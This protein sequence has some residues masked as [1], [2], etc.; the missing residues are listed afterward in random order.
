MKWKELLFLVR[1]FREFNLHRCRLAAKGGMTWIFPA[2]RPRLSLGKWVSIFLF[3]CS[4]GFSAEP[5]QYRS[6]TRLQPRPLKIHI[7]TFDLRNPEI[8]FIILMGKDPDGE[9]PAE[10]SLSDPKRLANA[11]HLI[12]GVNANAW[13]NLPEREGGEAPQTY[14]LDGYADALGWVLVDGVEKS[15]VDSSVWSFWIDPAGRGSIGKLTEPVPAMMAVSGFSGLLRD[16]MLLP[17]KEGPL[18]PRT[19]IGLDS[20]G[21]YVTLVVV[22]GR[23]KGDSEG[24][25]EY[26]LAE[27]MLELGCSDALN[28]DGGGSSTMLARGRLLNRPS[29]SLGL[30][31]VP[32]MLGIV[33][34][35][36]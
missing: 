31:P 10:A 4:S 20:E 18:H 14:Q 16:G 6:E 25:K 3:C 28:L 36:K 35:K 15:P 29:E 23:R 2:F 26:E 33:A 21:R 27:L 9:G 17:N 22:D 24:V 19:A 7:L 12:A 8:R 11:G 32:V 5:F 1:L 34:I 30:R 13:S